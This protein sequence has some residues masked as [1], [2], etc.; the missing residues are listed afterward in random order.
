M[1]ANPYLIGIH[2]KYIFFIQK[3]CQNY[4]LDSVGVNFVGALNMRMRS[5]QFSFQISVRFVSEEI[6][7]LRGHSFRRQDLATLGPRNL[8]AKSGLQFTHACV[9]LYVFKHRSSEQSGKDDCAQKFQTPK[10]GCCKFFALKRIE[11]HVRK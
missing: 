10:K 2:L 1:P 4:P 6:H 3:P 7:R 5:S 9:F 11:A 8:K